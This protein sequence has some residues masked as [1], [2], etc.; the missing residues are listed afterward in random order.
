[1]QPHFRQHGAH[2]SP[3]CAHPEIAQ[4]RENAFHT[5]QTQLAKLHGQ[6]QPLPWLH[7]ALTSLARAAWDPTTPQVERYWTGQLTASQLANAF[8][9]NISTS[10]LEHQFHKLEKSVTKVLL[11]LYNNG[12]INMLKNRG[13]RFHNIDVT[14]A[15]PPSTPASSQPH[16]THSTTKPKILQL[17]KVTS[18]P[19][20]APFTRP[21]AQHRPPNQIRKQTI[22]TIER[23]PDTTGN[24][25]PPATDSY[26]RIN[27]SPRTSRLACGSGP[28]E[29]LPKGRP[30]D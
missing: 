12:G 26:S 2:A 28:P 19:R 22:L 27:T 14:Q 11:P 3:I 20:A 24:L 7:T 5:Q 16:R 1:L 17:L 13:C 25:R 30:P 21:R 9:R 4:I 29:T 18:T 15:T 23:T 6:R 10:L 8:G